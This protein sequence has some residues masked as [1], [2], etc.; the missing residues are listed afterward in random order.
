MTSG[1]A[2]TFS[3]GTLSACCCHRLASLVNADFASIIIIN[4]AALCCTTKGRQHAV[5]TATPCPPP[6][7]TNIP[8]KQTSEKHALP[9]VSVFVHTQSYI[10]YWAVCLF[11]NQHQHKKSYPPRRKCKNVYAYFEREWGWGDMLI[12]TYSFL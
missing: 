11:A 5:F 7:L 3:P 8:L 10:C 1:C 9:L 4:G 2:I 12:L 6:R